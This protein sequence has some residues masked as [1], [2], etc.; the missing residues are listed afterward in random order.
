MK[1]YSKLP[2]NKYRDIYRTVNKVLR[3]VSYREIVLRMLVKQ[4]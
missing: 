4:F 3:Y 2:R 1:K